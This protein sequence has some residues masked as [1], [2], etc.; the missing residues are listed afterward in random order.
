MRGQQTPLELESWLRRDRSC[1][2]CLTSSFMAFFLSVLNNKHILMLVSGNLCSSSDPAAAS[3]THSLQRTNRQINSGEYSGGWC[4][5]QVIT[6]DSQFTLANLSASRH[7][8]SILL[9]DRHALPYDCC[10]NP[11]PAQ[12]L[13]SLTITTTEATIWRAAAQP[14]T[15]PR[16]SSG[17]HK[18]L[19]ETLKSRT[20]E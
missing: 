11:H 3:S 8:F 14:A 1:A 2:P 18:P 7:Y 17:H 19:Q 16:H 5:T 9:H 13:Q 12:L 15:R 10:Y 4:S 6:K 20:L